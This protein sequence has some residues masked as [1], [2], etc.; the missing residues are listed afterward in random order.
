MSIYTQAD[1]DAIDTKIKDLKIA[2]FTEGPLTVDTS[3][4]LDALIRQREVISTQLQTA[5]GRLFR[6]TGR[7]G[8][9]GNKPT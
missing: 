7:L 4:E 6:R 8:Y 9:T 2:V 3:R 1:L 5:S